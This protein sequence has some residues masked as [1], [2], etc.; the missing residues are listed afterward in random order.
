LV[1]A[2]SA[3]LITSPAAACWPTAASVNEW[4]ADQPERQ[5][6]DDRKKQDQQQPSRGR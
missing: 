2:V 6:A 4:A 1:S 5:E 3:L